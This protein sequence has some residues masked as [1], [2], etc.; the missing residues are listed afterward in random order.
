MSIA[1][2]VM[3][4]RA[5]NVVA[6]IEGMLSQAERYDSDFARGQA[7]GLTHALEVVRNSLRPYLT[8]TSIPTQPKASDR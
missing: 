7:S 6:V 1:E 5:L 4:E 8:P 2:T 3:Q